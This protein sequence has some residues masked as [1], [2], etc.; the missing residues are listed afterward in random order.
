MVFSLFFT[1]VSFAQAAP[2]A[3]MKKISLDDLGFEEQDKVANTE[4]SE[5]L[6][7]RASKLQT[8]QKLGLVTL[9]LIAA[10]VLTA[11][12]GK[13]ASDAHKI[14]GYA[15]A[16]SYGLTAYYSLSAPELELNQERKKWNTT[17]HKT[18][19]WIHLPLMILTPLAGYLADKSYREGKSPSGL[20]KMKGGLAG[21]L[22]ASL[23]IA[24]LAMV[25]D[26]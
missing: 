25:F 16:A 11:P 17:I 4:L 6:K 26:F 18:M 23:S 7:V 3:N 8:H 22:V 9:G 20:G 15:T 1:Q 13:R 2:K 10:T 5:N 12:E 24:S 14:L 19:A 21:G